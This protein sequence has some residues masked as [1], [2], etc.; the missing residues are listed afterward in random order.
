MHTFC[1]LPVN[2]NVKILKRLIGSRLNTVA[3]DHVHMGPGRN[4]DMEWKSKS[5]TYL[6]LWVAYGMVRPDGD[7]ILEDG[8]PKV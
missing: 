2:S 8:V 1:K 6:D 5:E 7:L 3:G 4:D